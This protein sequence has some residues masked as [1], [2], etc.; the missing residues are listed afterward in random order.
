VLAPRY[1]TLKKFD[2]V[3]IGTK[4]IKFPFEPWGAIM[5]LITK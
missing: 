2:E 4:M 3:Q 5:T 1:G